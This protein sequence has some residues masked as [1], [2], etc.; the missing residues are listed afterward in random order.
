MASHPEAMLDQTAVVRRRDPSGMLGHAAHFADQLGRGWAIS[1]AL[2][3][4]DTHRNAA[5]VAVLGMGGSAVC[6]DLARGIFAD[7]LQVPVISVRDYALPE[8]VT[9]RTM[10]VAISHSGATEETIAALATA[11]ERRCPVAVITT[12]GPIG[13][14]ARSVDLPRLLFPNETPPRASLGYT[15]ALFTGL[16]ERA[17]FLAIDDGELEQA[18]DAARAAAA[19]YGPDIATADN[20]AKQLA[21]SLLDRLP[22]IEAS[23][24]LAA[25]ARR[26]KTQF[27]ENSKSAAAA[28][29]VPEALHNAVVGYAQPDTLRDQLFVC[30]LAGSHDH[31]RNARRLDLSAKLLG[32]AGISHE[33]LSFAGPS[34][35]AEACTAI[36]LGDFASVYLGLLYGE[37]PSLTEVLTMVKSVMN[38]YDETDSTES[39]GGTDADLPVM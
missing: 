22:V 35:F 10:V 18:V 13:E 28:E 27:N 39:N 25:V 12:G 24:S 36:S 26:W 14:V 5:S 37:D 38:G 8:W 15:L 34:P 3:L 7:R 32:D 4:S 30:L 33:V 2:A 6:A 29:E 21:W 1:R 20:P 9:D 19:A 11:L 23:G 17:G 16:L 31:P